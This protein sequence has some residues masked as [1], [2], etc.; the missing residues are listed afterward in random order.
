MPTC[1]I[2]Y[3]W[4]T[5][6]VKGANI[7]P[8]LLNYSPYYAY[9]NIILK[10]EG[11]VKYIGVIKF[12]NSFKVIIHFW[13]KKINRESWSDKLWDSYLTVNSC[14]VIYYKRWVAG[15]KI[16]GTTGATTCSVFYIYFC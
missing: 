15:L 11:S 6:S 12:L 10:V 14:S 3:F 1:C 9:W 2:G 16:C 8:F 5:K 4:S 13:Y 7:V